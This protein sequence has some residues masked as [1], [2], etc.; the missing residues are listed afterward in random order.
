MSFKK[1]ESN[2]QSQ[3][4]EDGVIEE[5]FNIIGTTSKICVEFGAW[6]GIHFSNTWNLWRNEDW[7]A[8]LIEG[9]TVKYQD[10]IKNTQSF[11]KVKPLN[12][13]VTH[14][15]KN[16]LDNIFSDLDVENSIDLLSIDIDSDDYYVFKSLIIYN[17]RLIIVEYNPTIPP[18]LEI[19]QKPGEY[20]GCSALSLFKLG[21]EK[22]YNLVHMTDTNMFFVKGNEFEKMGLQ[23]L[24]ME[25]LFPTQHLTNIMT[26]YDGQAII[27]QVP[28]YMQN[29]IS[30]IKSENKNLRKIKVDSSVNL[31]HID[32][33]LKD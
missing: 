33:T 3:F 23:E 17:P 31:F 26:S 1:F 21:F 7:N 20:F 29:P 19:I 11:P 9:D 30:S 13:Y 14:E 27:N 22:N 24:K 18:H 16:S 15:G 28:V 32:I 6:D 25:E 2:I 10:L 8:I 4:G 12:M 5:I